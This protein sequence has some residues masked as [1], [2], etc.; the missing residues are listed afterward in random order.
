MP[1]QLDSDYQLRSHSDFDGMQAALAGILASFAAMAPAN[2]Q[3][4]VKAHPLDNGLTDWAKLCA[5]WSQDFAITDRFVFL[6][7]A[8]SNR[9]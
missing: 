7:P 5:A 2:C 4:A 9:S 3:L 1:L 8:T 6:K